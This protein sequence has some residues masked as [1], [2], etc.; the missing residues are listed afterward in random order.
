MI[1]QT[2]SVT[3]TST[4]GP[5]IGVDNYDEATIEEIIVDRSLIVDADVSADWLR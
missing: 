2:S 1:Q 3:L 4:A 5:G